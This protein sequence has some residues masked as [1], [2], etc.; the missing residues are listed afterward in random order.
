[1][2]QWQKE[3][4]HSLLDLATILNRHCWT[5]LTVGGLLLLSGWIVGDYSIILTAATL[6]CLAVVG[7]VVVDVILRYVR[8]RKKTWK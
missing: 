7:V 4:L 5:A 3:K 6:I 2:K 1:M 8:W